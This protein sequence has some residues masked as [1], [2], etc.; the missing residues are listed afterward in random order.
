LNLTIRDL[1]A[2]GDRRSIAQSGRV[3]AMIEADPSRVAEIAGLTADADWLVSQRA[4]DLLE[5]IAHDHVEWIEPHKQLF[6]GPTAESDKWEIRLQIVR[7]LPLFS[8]SGK[9]LSR[10][11]AIL[12][13]N[14][15]H[16]QTFVKAW[17]LDSLSTFAMKD[18]S[19]LRTVRRR[20]DEFEC[21][22]SKALQARARKIRQ[23][24]D[25]TVCERG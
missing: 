1:L 16:P 22:A 23:R 11:T 12:Q 24:L 19:L 13:E 2:G 18:R 15:N 4:F 20:L 17:S 8:W 10:A 6:L 7:A 21:S 5:K 3:R 25:G 9:D 14:V